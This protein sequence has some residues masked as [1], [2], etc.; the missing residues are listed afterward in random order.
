MVLLW[1]GGGDRGFDGGRKVTSRFRHSR[2]EDGIR[3]R[4]DIYLAVRNHV[5]RKGLVSYK[6]ECF[7]IKVLLL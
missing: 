7:R 5:V 6:E 2:I 1:E 4:E 3:V